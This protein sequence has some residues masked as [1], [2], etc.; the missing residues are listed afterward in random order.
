MVLIAN[1]LS[2]LLYNVAGMFVTEELGAVSRTVFE[3]AR[4]LFVFVGDLLL[5]YTHTGLGEQW[6][7][8]SYLQACPLQMP[9]SPSAAE[10]QPASSRHA[11]ETFAI[12]HLTASRTADS[13]YVSIHHL[14]SALWLHSAEA[15]HGV[16]EGGRISQ[17]HLCAQAAGFLVLVAGT[18]VYAQ[19]DR[20]QE[21]QEKH[22]HDGPIQVSRTTPAPPPQH[23]AYIS[24]SKPLAKSAHF[25]ASLLGALFSSGMRCTALLT[26]AV[27]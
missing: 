16:S 18:L 7:N 6:D 15:A 20:K 17:A 21:A 4:T 14:L 9:F 26:I 22:E 23:S 25:C 12:T 5:Y 2:L 24:N 11:C 13:G 19:G 27:H 1:S 8:S 3:S 10:A